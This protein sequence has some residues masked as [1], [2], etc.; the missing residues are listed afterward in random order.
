MPSLPLRIETT[1]RK[2]ALKGRSVADE[3]P[4]EAWRRALG[5]LVPRVSPE[6]SLARTATYG[7]EVCASMGVS[8][9]LRGTEPRGSRR[10]GCGPESTS[11]VVTSVAPFQ[12][13]Y[14]VTLLRDL[15]PS[16][17][18]GASVGWPVQEKRKAR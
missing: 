1:G 2:R 5:A 15:F 9:P 12:L 6:L 8:K 13:A 10:S 7:S 18:A 4:G 14:R 16:A 3:A 17:R 11:Q